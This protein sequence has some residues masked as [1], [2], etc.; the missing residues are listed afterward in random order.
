MAGF[1]IMSKRK[2]ACPSC[3]KP[4]TVMDP[5][6]KVPHHTVGAVRKGQVVQIKCPGVGKNPN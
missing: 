2:I 1:I 3:G 5:D 4:V 6:P